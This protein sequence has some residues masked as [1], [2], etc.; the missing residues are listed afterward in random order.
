MSI[1]GA[2]GLG[3][4]LL[5]GVTGAVSASKARREQQRQIKE[6]KAARQGWFNRNYYQNYL[7]STEAQSAMTRLRDT[8]RRRGEENRA[9]A[10]IAGATE[11]AA[12]ARQAND[13]EAVAQAMQGLAEKGDAIKRQTDAKYMGYQSD[14]DN[15]QMQQLQLDE[16][17]GHQ[18][19]GNSVGLLGS[20]LSMFDKNKK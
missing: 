18:L 5:G 8:L 7:D 17:G 2:I 9:A 11:E 15:Q 3:T 12:V 6:Q 19:L 13:S 10:A 20:A 16:Q 4:S 1:L 14:I